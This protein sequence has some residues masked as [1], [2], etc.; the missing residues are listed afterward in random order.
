MIGGWRGYL[1]GSFGLEYSEALSQGFCVLRDARAPATKPPPVTSNKP[2]PVQETNAVPVARKLMVEM[3]P[4]SIVTLIGFNRTS[5]APWER[6]NQLSFKFEPPTMYGNS[7]RGEYWDVINIH[8]ENLA[9]I[10]KRLQAKTIEMT[11]VPVTNYETTVYEAKTAKE[12]R[13]IENYPYALVVDA[14][15]PREWFLQEPFRVPK[16]KVQEIKATYPGSFRS[17]E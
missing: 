13:V 7:D 8:M 2:A 17:G 12:R 5:P 10:M 15:I 3:G 16:T 11:I 4:N 9:E 1:R 14:R 6:G